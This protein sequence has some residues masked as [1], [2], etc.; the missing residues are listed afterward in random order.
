MRLSEETFRPLFYTI[1]EWAVYNEPPS[2]T[3]EEPLWRQIHYQILLKT[4][5]NL[6][7]VRLATL[8]VLQEL[9]R[10]LGMNYQSLL[11][12]AIPFMA[13]LMEDPNDEV[14]KTCHRVIVDMEST[15][16]ESL[17]DYFNN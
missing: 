16:G 1:Y 10:K 8:N 13:E 17:Q 2:A 15:L 11:P 14:E 5:S 12:E 9:S 4:R 7:K 3:K 6:S